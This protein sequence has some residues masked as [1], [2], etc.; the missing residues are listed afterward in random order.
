PLD[1][2]MAVAL[3]VVNERE[4]GSH[5]EQIRNVRGSD[6]FKT[7]SGH[8]WCIRLN[9]GWNPCIQPIDAKSQ[10]QR[11][12]SR[13]CP[14]VLS[15]ESVLLQIRM[16]IARIVVERYLVAGNGSIGGGGVARG[17]RSRQRRLG[18]ID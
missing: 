10:V 17:E 8:E 6:C 9:L 13:H 15:K 7:L 16:R 12:S 3:D 5:R 18:R 14:L 2:H 11:Q 1:G 4:P